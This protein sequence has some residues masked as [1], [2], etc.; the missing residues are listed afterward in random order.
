[1]RAET[2]TRSPRRERGSPL[3]GFGVGVCMKCL[4][5][6]G[7]VTRRI[8]GVPSP[9]GGVVSRAIGPPARNT[10]PTNPDSPRA[11]DS[12][13]GGPHSPVVRVCPPWRVGVYAGTGFGEGGRLGVGVLSRTGLLWWCF[14]VRA[15]W[16]AAMPGGREPVAKRGA[17]QPGGEA[18]ACRSPSRVRPA[19]GRELERLILAQ[20]SRGGI[21]VE[22]GGPP[23]NFQVDG[24]PG[25]GVVLP[26]ARQPIR[27]PRSL[28]VSGVEGCSVLPVG[29]V[30]G[31]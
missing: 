26:S 22:A 23:M 15:C 9:S 24:L 7:F 19:S 28:W 2:G 16:A 13:T 20:A 10:D 4:C 1:V 31:E 21:G 25:P 27:D 8:S 3:S 17:H 14:P 11:A 18:P 5:I 12:G 29:G 30:R 6:V